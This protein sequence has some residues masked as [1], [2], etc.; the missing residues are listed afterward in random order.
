MKL[1]KFTLSFKLDLLEI[2]REIDEIIGGEG[3]LAVLLNYLLVAQDAVVVQ[4]VQQQLLTAHTKINKL[5]SMKL[6]TP[7]HDHT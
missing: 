6:S 7:I 5:Y 3:L 1:K 2:D 4:H